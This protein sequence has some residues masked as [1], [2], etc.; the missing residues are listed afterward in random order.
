[1]VR[2]LAAG[3]RDPQGEPL[4]TQGL[5]L[6]DRS[7]TENFSAAVLCLQLEAVPEARDEIVALLEARTKP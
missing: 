5:D 3:V 4:M 6:F 7:S 2:R 1:M